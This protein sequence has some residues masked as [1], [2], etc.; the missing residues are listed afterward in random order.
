MS[1][2]SKFLEALDNLCREHGVWLEIDDDSV[3]LVD[4][5]YGI[6]AIGLYSDDDSQTYKVAIDCSN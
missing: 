3:N 6:I 2:V 4:E 5:N 1:K